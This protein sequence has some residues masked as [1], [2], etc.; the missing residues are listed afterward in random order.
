MFVGS[1]KVLSGR[2]SEDKTKLKEHLI[3]A[4]VTWESRV[5]QKP[6]GSMQSKVPQGHLP[7]PNRSYPWPMNFQVTHLIEQWLSKEGFLT[8]HNVGG[9]KWQRWCSPD[10]RL[11]HHKYVSIDGALLSGKTA[12]R[13]SILHHKRFRVPGFITY[14]KVRREQSVLESQG[15]R[16]PNGDI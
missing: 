12:I 13:N 8:F 6:Q 7:F 1:K 16:G 4:P 9:Y 15:E 2:W 10:Y 3:L 5:S 14:A 11:I